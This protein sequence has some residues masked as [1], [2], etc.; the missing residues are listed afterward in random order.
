MNDLGL[1]EEVLRRASPSAAVRKK[2]EENVRKALSA[3]VVT[4]P[5]GEAQRFG[6][7]GVAALERHVGVMGQPDLKKLLK[8]WDQYR[9]ITRETTITELQ[10][11]AVALLNADILPTPK[12]ASA[13]R[14][15][16]R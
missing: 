5:L 8:T 15:R 13:S 16:A 1:L 14:R 3:S 10:E 7:G 2:V 9:K 12:P 6:H 11:V 4:L